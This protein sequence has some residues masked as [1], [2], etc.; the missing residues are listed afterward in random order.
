MSIQRL[1][2]LMEVI[3]DT[4]TSPVQVYDHSIAITIVNPAAAQTDTIT[5]G[6]VACSFTSDGTPTKQEVSNGLIAA[7][8]GSDAADYFT[9]VQG[10]AADYNIFLKPLIVPTP[11]IAVSANLASTPV[12]VEK[13]G[14][15]LLQVVLDGLTDWTM[16]QAVRLRSLKFMPSAANDFITVLEVVP[17]VSQSLWPALKL[18]SSSGDPVGCLFHSSVD[19]RVMIPFAQCNL[20]TA[21][22]AVV[23]FEFI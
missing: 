16:S 20:S 3:A 9:V 13:W 11:S 15:T 21:A 18:E 14:K 1:T 2:E 4:P 8:A 12:T 10:A 7:I 22:N 6:G 5:L 17:G 23:T 19:T